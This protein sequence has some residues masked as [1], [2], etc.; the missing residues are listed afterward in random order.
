MGFRDWAGCEGG[1]LWSP[2]Q[3][4]KHRT[5][6][7]MLQYRHLDLITFELPEQSI[8]CNGSSI[9]FN[10]RGRGSCTF[11]CS[12]SIKM[13]CS[14]RKERVNRK[15]C[16]MF[17]SNTFSLSKCVYLIVN[18]FIHEYIWE[19]TFFPPK[20]SQISNI[21]WTHFQCEIGVSR[22]T[23]AP[24][25]FLIFFLVTFMTKRNADKQIIYL[26][27]RFL[28]RLSSVS[29]HGAQGSVHSINPI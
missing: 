24:V 6:L 27:L 25:T 8:Y 12:R 14:I 22:N 28:F 2:V 3:P 5:T 1:S 15:K 7:S 10:A 17:S 13:F 26:F 29:K 16:S 18:R 9:H 4:A 21:F 19:L 23:M 11:F 20:I